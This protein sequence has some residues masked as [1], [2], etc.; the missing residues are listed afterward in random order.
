M[1]KTLYII[2]TLLS[3]QSS[4]KKIETKQKENNHQQ[5]KNQK[6]AKY[7][8]YFMGYNDSS[9]AISSTFLPL[10]S[11]LLLL[12]IT[13]YAFIQLLTR[14]MVHSFVV[15]STKHR[16]DNKFY[17]SVR[18]Y[19]A[20]DYVDKTCPLPLWVSHFGYI[21]SYTLYTYTCEPSLFTNS[22]DGYKEYEKICLATCRP[23]FCSMLHN[24]TLFGGSKA[25]DVI[26]MRL[27]PC[28]AQGL[29]FGWG[30][31]KIHKLDLTSITHLMIKPGTR[32]EYYTL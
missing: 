20:R 12:L 29:P 14:F 19:S 11:S 16:I 10:S 30:S 5:K 22:Y 28:S 18:P 8:Q 17:I 13:A 4:R 7:F 23:S 6:N 26:C 25:A 31:F 15:L 1:K 27:L 3:R 2:N 21:Y 9:T 32:Q 24:L